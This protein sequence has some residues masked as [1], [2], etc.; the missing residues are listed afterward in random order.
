MMALESSIRTNHGK[1]G[2]MILIPGW[3]SHAN[4]K[5]GNE[6]HWSGNDFI[7]HTCIQSTLI[8]PFTPLT[9]NTRIAGRGERW[10]K[11][12]FVL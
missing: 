4:F 7:L 3:K 6:V 12:P 1:H 2:Y 9:Y 8:G 11:E 10:A 5:V